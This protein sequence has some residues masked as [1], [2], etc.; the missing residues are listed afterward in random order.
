MRCTVTYTSGQSAQEFDSIQAAAK[1]LLAE[2]PAG[3][4]YDAGGWDQ[5]EDSS[6]AA[7]DVRGTR[8]GLVWASESDSVNDDGAKAVAAIEV[9]E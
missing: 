8:A 2:Y 9:A 7:Y 3:V 5:D 6:D 1:A 4:I